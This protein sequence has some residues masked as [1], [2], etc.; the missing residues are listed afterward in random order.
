MT[1][2]NCASENPENQQHFPGELTLAFP[3]IESLKL[4]TGYVSP[5]ILV[6]LDCGYTELVIP[7]LK[8][9]Q[10]RKGMKAYRS[11]SGLDSP[12]LLF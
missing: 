3:S 12:V 7:E 1:C 2:K 8:L 9:K 5:E 4:S 6:C 10:L 11:K